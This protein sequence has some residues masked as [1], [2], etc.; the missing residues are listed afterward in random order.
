MELT[1]LY[2]ESNFFHLFHS[3]FFIL[4]SLLNLQ[5]Y[6]YLSLITTKPALAALYALY[7]FWL[8]RKT[9]SVDYIRIPLY[10]HA[11][12][13]TTETVIPSLLPMRLPDR[14][15]GSVHEDKLVSDCWFLLFIILVAD[16]VPSWERMDVVTCMLEIWTSLRLISACSIIRC[17]STRSSNNKIWTVRNNSDRQLY[18][19]ETA[20]LI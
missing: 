16:I 6:F 19:Q 7:L 9:M 12:Y 8:T 15:V 4:Y 2:Q 10:R 11:F 14:Q 13:L 5:T 18:V 1:L 3:F 17:F 20:N